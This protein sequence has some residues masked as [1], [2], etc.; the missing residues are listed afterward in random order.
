MEKTQRNITFIYNTVTLAN[1]DNKLQIPS[2]SF[3]H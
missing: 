2:T 1:E 3:F